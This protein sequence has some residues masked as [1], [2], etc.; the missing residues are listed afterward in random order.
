MDSIL[1][2]QAHGCQLIVQHHS[3]TRIRVTAFMISFYVVTVTIMRPLFTLWQGI[4]E[5]GH[6]PDSKSS[7]DWKPRLFVLKRHPTSGRSSLDFYKSTSKRWQ[8]QSIM[9]VLSLW[10]EFEISLAHQC[11]YKFTLRL[12]TAENVIY[13]ASSNQSSMNK[14]LY[15]IQTQR[16]LEPNRGM[17]YIGIR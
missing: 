12:T 11:S 8:R 4:L 6:N 17:T 1:I 14:W 7:K 3:H 15:H 13:L 2:L 5:I 9:G 10:P 16:I